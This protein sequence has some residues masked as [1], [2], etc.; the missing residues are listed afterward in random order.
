[1]MT[2]LTFTFSSMI[3]AYMFSVVYVHVIPIIFDI[4]KNWDK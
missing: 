3:V 2:I 1:M 4:V